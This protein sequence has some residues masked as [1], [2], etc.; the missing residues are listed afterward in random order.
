M[1]IARIERWYELD[2]QGEDELETRLSDLERGIRAR[3]GAV[4]AIRPRANARP[5]SVSV[6]CE[7]PVTG[8]LRRL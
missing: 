8:T 1:Q 7:L 4:L 6:L 3:G 2:H 5:A